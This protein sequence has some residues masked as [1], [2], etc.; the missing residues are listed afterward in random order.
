MII[1]GIEVRKGSFENKEKKNVVYH[2]VLFHGLKNF[3]ESESSI[4]S[5]GH[6]SPEPNKIRYSDIPKYFGKQLSDNEL[7]AL[8]GR[9]LVFLYEN[10]DELLLVQ[11]NKP[12]K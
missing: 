5:A 10:D 4:F 12:A 2:N 11:E 8:V 7:E 9:D 3:K 6:R 1:I